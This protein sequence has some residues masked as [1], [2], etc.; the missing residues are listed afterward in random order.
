[1][2]ASSRT[3]SSRIVRGS[4][5]P[6]AAAYRQSYAARTKK[7]PEGQSPSAKEQYAVLQRNLANFQ[8]AGAQRRETEQYEALEQSQR[9]FQLAGEKQREKEQV[10]ALTQSAAHPVYRPVEELEW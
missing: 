10:I 7:L 4:S 9:A 6:G 1:M 3:E 5:G 2:T 8:K